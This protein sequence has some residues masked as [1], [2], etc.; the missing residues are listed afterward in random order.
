MHTAA[1][2]K[3]GG[4]GKLLRPLSCFRKESD[5]D[6]N[7]DCSSGSGRCGRA[8]D[9]AFTGMRDEEPHLRQRQRLGLRHGGVLPADAATSGCLLL[10]RRRQPQPDEDDN[11]ED[12]YGLAEGWRFVLSAPDLDRQAPLNP[13]TLDSAEP[14]AAAAAFAV[15]ACGVTVGDGFGAGPGG[16]TEQRTFSLARSCQGGFGFTLVGSQP[17]RV[18]K[19]D[20]GS[21]AGLAGIRSGDIVV[22]INGDSVLSC[23]CDRVVRAIRQSPG[24]LEIRVQRWLAD[25]D[26]ATADA[27]N[28]RQPQPQQQQQQPQQQQILQ[29]EPFSTF[30]L[31]RRGFNNQ[32][33][34]LPPPMPQPS[35]RPSVD[36][37]A[38]EAARQAAVAR[39]AS[40]EEAFA[41]GLAACRQ[42]YADRLA[43]FLTPDEH[44]AMFFNLEDLLEASCSSL[45]LIR[46]S[47]SLRGLVDNAGQIYRARLY[48]LCDQYRDYADNLNATA[49]RLL[50][51]LLAACPEARTALR[52]ARRSAPSATP[53]PPLRRCLTEPVR[54]LRR[55]AAIFRDLL[56][57]TPPAHYDHM[58]A[59]DVAQSLEHCAASLPASTPGLHGAEEDDEDD[60]ENFEDEDGR[61]KDYVN[62]GNK[63]YKEFKDSGLEEAD[64]AMSPTARSLV[65]SSSGVSSADPSAAELQQQRR[66]HSQWCGTNSSQQQPSQQL[67]QHQQPQH[68]QQ[69][70]LSGHLVW[71]CRDSRQLPAAIGAHAMLLPDLLILAPHRREDAAAAGPILSQPLRLVECCSAQ[72]DFAQNPRLLCL[73]FAGGRTLLLEAP[74]GE[75]KQLWR[76]CIT[77]RLGELSGWQLGPTDCY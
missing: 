63:D 20:A 26:R 15:P 54:H 29:Q 27:A 37:V 75:A 70:I 11:G 61:Y 64:A 36:E 22:S 52:M 28:P 10:R 12:P 55:L 19:V 56:E 30:S 18:G 35:S 23:C 48:Q 45:S 76:S 5:S 41:L 53:L 62:A 24:R 69:E 50:R 57:A 72:F 43:E 73:S 38:N 7:S 40:S 71:H 31:S 3:R 47:Q 13:P 66:R 60:Y 1:T 67:R 25:V 6:S 58:F 17:T 68:R 77:R 74:S 34:P 44:R 2:Q 9:L 21:A 4:L 16:R 59:E 46:Q 51:A 14:A 42:F 32:M 39:L 65:A 8:V 49:L 33:Q